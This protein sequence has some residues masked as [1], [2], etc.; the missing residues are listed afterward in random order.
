M[1]K[2]Y[3]LQDDTTGI[4]ALREFKSAKKALCF[5]WKE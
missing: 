3:R 2:S 5:A 4:K 1:V